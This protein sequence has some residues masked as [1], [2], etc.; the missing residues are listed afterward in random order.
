MSDISDGIGGMVEGG[1]PF[2][3]DGIYLAGLIEVHSFLRAAIRGGDTRLIELL[4]VG[5]IDLSDLEAMNMLARENLI[6]RPLYMPPWA[7]DMRY[8][9]AYLS[10]STFLNQIDIG[11]V[12]ER[13]SNLLGE[14]TV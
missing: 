2:T 9:L 11:Q 10:Y 6:E 5:K 8:L 14:D 1:A 3:K 7:K 4:F 13:Y 12:A